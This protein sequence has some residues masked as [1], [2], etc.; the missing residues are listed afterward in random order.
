[1][2]S[3]FTCPKKR[4]SAKVFGVFENMVE[5]YLGLATCGKLQQCIGF[6]ATGCQLVT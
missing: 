2:I 6:L 1:M 5:L 3:R 4:F